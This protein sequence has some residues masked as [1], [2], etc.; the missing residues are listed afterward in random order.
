MKVLFQLKPI[1]L[2]SLA[3]FGPHPDG[4]RNGVRSTVLKSN[5]V[6]SLVSGQPWEVSEKSV[7]K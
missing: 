4:I 1:H 2:L 7:C 3:M 5:I 6:N